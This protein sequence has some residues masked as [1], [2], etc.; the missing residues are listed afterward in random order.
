MYC[1]DGSA[2]FNICR[3]SLTTDVN[4][5]K[6]LSANKSTTDVIAYTKTLLANASDVVG[7]AFTPSPAANYLV[8]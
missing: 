5:V 4:K 2:L 7:R 3:L 8:A 1:F 6:N